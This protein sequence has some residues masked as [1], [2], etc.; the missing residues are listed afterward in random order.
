MGGSEVLA[1]DSEKMGDGGGAE[2]SK[3]FHAHMREQ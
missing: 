1:E 2:D 3:G